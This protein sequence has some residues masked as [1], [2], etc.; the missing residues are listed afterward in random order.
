MDIYDG[1]P[2][3][4][5]YHGKTLTAPISIRAV[6]VA[7]ASYAFMASPYPVIISAEVHCG[8]EQQMKLVQVLKEVFGESLVSSDLPGVNV[9]EG[10]VLPSPEQL[11]YRILFKVSEVLGVRRRWW[12]GD[13][14]DGFHGDSLRDR[15]RRKDEDRLCQGNSH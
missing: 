7:I 4:I 14:L 13:N 10:G 2:E 5:V 15:W 12:S 8:P 6:F 1:E 3:P 11:R 9:R